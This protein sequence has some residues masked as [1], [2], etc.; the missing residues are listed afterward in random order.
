MTNILWLRQLFDRLHSRLFTFR[1]SQRLEDASNH[2]EAYHASMPV[3][4]EEKT[5]LQP[6]RHLETDSR[7]QSKTHGSQ[8]EQGQR[9]VSSGNTNVPS[10]EEINADEMEHQRYG[11]AQPQLVPTDMIETMITAKGRKTDSLSG[12]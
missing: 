3:I 10:K 1:E 4:P 11:D 2:V 8:T 6:K 9:D 5:S 7:Q 12:A